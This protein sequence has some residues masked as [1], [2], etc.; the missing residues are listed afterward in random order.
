MM[1]KEKMKNRKRKNHRITKTRKK[2]NHKRR[3]KMNPQDNIHKH[4][5]EEY[6]EII[7]NV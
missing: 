3:E 7:F 5:Q 1:M 4:H 2:S 6:K